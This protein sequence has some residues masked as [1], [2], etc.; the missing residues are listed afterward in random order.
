MILGFFRDQTFIRTLS[1]GLFF[2]NILEQDKYKFATLA[3]QNKFYF[4]KRPNKLDK[5][6]RTYK[7]PLEIG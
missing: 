3:F 5:R 2:L 1:Y 4:I 7:T 6:Y